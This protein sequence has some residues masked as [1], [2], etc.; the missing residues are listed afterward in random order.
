MNEC[1]SE[2]LTNL[3]I[4]NYFGDIRDETE[5]KAVTIDQKYCNGA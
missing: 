2:V 1:V 4:F 3:R 5:E